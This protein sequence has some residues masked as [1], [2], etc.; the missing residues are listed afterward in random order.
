MA[1]KQNRCW[2]GYEP[3]PGKEP[4]SQGSCKPKA[5][6]KSTPSEKEFK[7]KRKKQLDRW[8]KKTGGKRQAAQ[9]LEGPD[10]E[11]SSQKGAA[12]KK[13][14]VGKPAAAKR[15]KPAKNPTA[16]KA[17]AKKS[18][19]KKTAVEKKTSARSKKRTA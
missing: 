1:T 17:A 16:K 5:D 13:K 15:Q 9:H 12:A 7:V 2:P 6:S 4:H 10:G 8:Q 19:A 14:A 18:S 11:P 3:V